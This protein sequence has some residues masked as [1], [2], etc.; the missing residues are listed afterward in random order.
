VALIPAVLLV[1]VTFWYRQP[2]LPTVAKTVR[3]TNDFKVKL[4][5]L[6][7]TDGLYL[8][9]VEGLPETTGSKIAQ[10][11]TGGGETTWIA[12]NVPE[13]FLIFGISP[14]RR[15]L[16]VANGV[17]KSLGTA[18]VWV[19]PLPAGTAHRL[20]NISA[21]SAAW[22]P[23]GRHILYAEE[24]TINLINEDGTE[25]RT[26]A[27]VPGAARGLRFSPDGR[28]VRF[29]VAQ[30]KGES[31]TIWEMDAEGQNPHPLFPNW[32]KS[33]Y[34]CCGNWSPSGEYYYFEA[35]VDNEQ[36]I[37]VRP[38]LHSIFSRA[39]ASPSLVTAGP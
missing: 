13:P 22:A 17:G 19:Q 5:A 37:W 4:P 33:S 39:P 35:G 1:S 30:S 28:G 23:D 15:K 10:L 29:W 2:Q 3:L 12:T 24:S 7:V 34:Q 8:Y 18:E 20:S 38:E 21:S 25:S 27:K 16:L 9:F 6:P 14:D 26:V 36:G 11:S 32:N 31:N